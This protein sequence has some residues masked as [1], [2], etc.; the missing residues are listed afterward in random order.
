MKPSSTRAQDID[1]IKPDSTHLESWNLIH[2]RL[3]WLPRK[4]ASELDPESPNCPLNIRTKGLPRLLIPRRSEF[5]LRAN[6]SSGYISGGR[7]TI[8]FSR[9]AL[10]RKQES[11]FL[12]EGGSEG[13]VGFYGRDSREFS[14]FF[15]LRS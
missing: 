11:R 10:A 15:S 13:I 1:D 14:L 4:A 3:L 5:A 12:E 6:V 2:L 7:L 8:P 9:Q